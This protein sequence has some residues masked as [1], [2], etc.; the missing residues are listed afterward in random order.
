MDAGARRLALSA[1]LEGTRPLSGLTT[2]LS[3]GSDRTLRTFHAIREAKA[4]YGSQVIES[5]IISMTET[6]ADVLEAAVLAREAG[7]ID[8][9]RDITEIGLVPLVETIEDLRH[10]GE[11]LD[12]LFSDAQ[13]RRILS[14]RGDNQEVVLGYSDSNK[15]G[16]ITT[17]QWEIY[18]AQRAMRN[19]AERQGI[20]L[21]LFH[22]RGGTI[23]RGGGP[24]HAAILAQ[25]YGTIDGDLKV[26]EQGEVISEKYGHPQIA[27]RNLELALASVLES[28]LLHRRSR[29]PKEV[30][31]R[32]TEAMDCLSAEAYASYR[33]FVRHPS[34]VPYFLSST[35]VEELGRLNLGSRPSRRPG[36]VGGIED[37]RAIPWVFG[38]TQT[39]Q[40]VPGWLGVGTGIRAARKAGYGEVLAEMAGEWA[41]F[42]TFLSNVEM[43]LAKTDLDIAGRYVASLV[44][45]EH[46]GLLDL[47]RAECE[48]TTDEVLALRQEPDLLG[49]LPL[50][51]RTL[52]VRDI[53]LDPI[54]YLQVS[55]LAR[56]RAGESGDELTRALL[57]TVN[58]IAAGMRNTG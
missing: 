13:Y 5:Y 12:E 37:L 3:E 18:K 50:L 16:G 57:L 53:Y 43:T 51:K 4:R 49:D 24:T 44:P 36:G 22:G 10:A 2:S 48:L 46:R 39:R 47:L 54:N 20:H 6:A 40:I 23:G 27:A 34:L 19:V 21:R 1:E 26:T 25:P 14:L 7:L 9:R 15:E 38:W 41:F 28:S 52:G 17:S 29:K 32:W 55:L 45:A 33:D 30:L 42:Q 31:D 11:L 8:L 35:P 58:G 56:S